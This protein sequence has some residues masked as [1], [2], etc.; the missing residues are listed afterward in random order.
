ML[1]CVIPHSVHLVQHDAYQRQS[2]NLMC[3]KDMDKSEPD[4]DDKKTKRQIKA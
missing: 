3:D 2:Y 1:Q 4:S